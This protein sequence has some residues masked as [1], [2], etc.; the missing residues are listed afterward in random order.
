MHGSWLVRCRGRGHEGTLYLVF[1]S[2]SKHTEKEPARSKLTQVNR[3][4]STKLLDCRT[5]S[6]RHGEVIASGFER[7]GAVG[8][9]ALVSAQV[10]TTLRNLLCML[11]STLAWMGSS[12]LG[13]QRSVHESGD[14]LHAGRLGVEYREIVDDWNG[15][16]LPVLSSQQFRLGIL[17]EEVECREGASVN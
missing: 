11:L 10:R 1:M 2:A 13:E 7:V 3:S 8:K 5:A 15:N 12:L 16:V 4:L 14:E 17:Y 9:R 6:M